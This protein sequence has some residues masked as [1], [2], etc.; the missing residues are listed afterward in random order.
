MVSNAVSAQLTAGALAFIGHTVAVDIS[1][2]EAGDVAFV[3]YAVFVA[4]L[5]GA[6]GNV[7]NVRGGVG[8]AVSRRLT[9]VRNAVSVAVVAGS[10]TNVAKVTYAVRLAVLVRL[11]LVGNVVEVAIGTATAAGHVTS[12]SRRTAGDIAV[13]LDGV[14]VTVPRDSQKIDVFFAVERSCIGQVGP[15]VVRDHVV[16]ISDFILKGITLR[17]IPE[18]G[19]KRRTHRNVG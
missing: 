14:A 19:I 12:A 1:G 9:L 2:R 8:L 4:V 6:L 5:A 7:A 15:T 17:G 3:R 16:V 13:V 10:C 11:A 18:T